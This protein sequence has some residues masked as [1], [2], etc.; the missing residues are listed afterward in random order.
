[1][2]VERRQ[3]NACLSGLLPHSP[4][5]PAQR[6]AGPQSGRGVSP[7]GWLC[8]QVLD[9]QKGW[10]CLL[11]PQARWELEKPIPAQQAGKC[12]VSGGSGQTEAQKGR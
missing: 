7:A 2:F 9:P 3:K 11:Q 8:Q 1:M 10:A 12:W 5:S 6:C 4:N